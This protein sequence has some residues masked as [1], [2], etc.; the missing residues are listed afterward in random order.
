MP[1][2]RVCALV[3][4]YAT[5][6]GT[7]CQLESPAVEPC[8]RPRNSLRPIPAHPTIHTP[9]SQPPSPLTSSP[10]IPIKQELCSMTQKYRFERLK[11]CMRIRISFVKR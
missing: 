8:P 3:S 1:I 2:W 6:N 4:Y 11:S 5:I 7:T 10:Q 9:A